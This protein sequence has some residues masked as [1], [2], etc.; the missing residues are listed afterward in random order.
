M[1]WGHIG[2]HLTICSDG[3][4]RFVALV[5]LKHTMTGNAIWHCVNCV[6]MSACWRVDERWRVVLWP[7]RIHALLYNVMTGCMGL[8]SKILHMS[9]CVNPLMES[10]GP[11]SQNIFTITESL[12]ISAVQ[13]WE[14][15]M[16]PLSMKPAEHET[17]CIGE[18]P[19]EHE[20]RHLHNM[21]RSN[22]HL[23]H[24]L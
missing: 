16:F 3:Y 6:S 22:Q 2:A 19:I 15:N 14:H 4:G 8:T 12:N 1:H 17:H 18:E 7:I 23:K 21:L 20:T 11:W 5:L 13:L 24:L 10:V 9:D